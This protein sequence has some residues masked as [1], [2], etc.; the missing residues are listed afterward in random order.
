M[1]SGHKFESL[2]SPISSGLRYDF[3][4]IILTFVDLPT[5]WIELVQPERGMLGLTTDTS[6]DHEDKAKSGERY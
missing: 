3:K 4:I 5:E 6:K 1:K 2:V